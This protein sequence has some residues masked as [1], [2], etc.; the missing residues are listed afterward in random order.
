MPVSARETEAVKET[1][2]PL[3]LRPRIERYAR[4][5]LGSIDPD[6]LNIRFKWWGLYTQRPAEDGYFMLRIRIPGGA[7]TAGQI[8]TIGGIA[9]RYGRD[10]ADLTDR[11]N[12]QLHWL[13]I[14]DIPAVW[15][16]LAA[17]GLSSLQACGDTVR[18]IL[19]CPVAGIDADEVFDA[20]PDLLAADRRLTGTKEFSNLPRKFKMSISACRDHCVQQEIN[21]VG[22]VGVVHPDGR[23]GY[24]VLVGGGLSN[25][26][27]FA[28]RL[29]VFVPR[30]EVTEVLAAITAL[31]RDHGGRDKRTHARLKFLVAAW[32]S[33]RMRKVLETDYLDRDLEDGDAAPAS[34]SVHRDHVGIHR[35]HDGNLYV[36]TSPL[37]GRTTGERLVEV[38]RIARELG[39]GRVRLTSQQKLLVLDV[40]EERA[41]EA[42]AR[43]DALDLPARPSPFRRGAMACTGLQFCKLALVETKQPAAEL[44]SALEARFPG[45]EGK[46]RLNVNGCPNSCA[47]YQ[48]ADIG[49]AGGESA[50]DGNYQLH[51]GGDLG[52]GRAFGHRVRDRVLADD[53]ENVTERLLETY[54]AEREEDESLQS[55][56]RRQPDQALAAHAA[57]ER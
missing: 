3:D 39:R 9:G 51:L 11:Q 16:E 56:L 27:H 4:D 44:V 49:L 13:R 21:D 10:L 15:D 43:L 17:V 52:E 42:V 41:S 1:L 18:N 19:G 32:G 31:F 37:V 46:I 54:L 23:R 6:D 25:T 2:D 28:Q 55:W 36:G 34:T 50:G 53:I 38:G 20:T 33:E 26:P 8:E 47:R 12:I 30:A 7:L 57:A 24:D 14:E 40:P 35:Q 22:L 45:F 29:G 5:G 48:L